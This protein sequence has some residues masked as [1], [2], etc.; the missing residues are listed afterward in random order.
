MVYIP[1]S[2]FG[3]LGFFVMAAFLLSIFSLEDESSSISKLNDAI[4]ED[5]Q[6]LQSIPER[7][8]NESW[9]DAISNMGTGIWYIFS[10]MFMV[11]LLPFFLFADLLV[12]LLILPKEFYIVGVFLGMG[13]FG[14]I[15]NF[16]RGLRSG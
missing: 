4:S 5:T 1:G 9:Y 3:I 16:I 8:G 2:V 15:A 6:S 12:Y 10:I 13:L 14:A 7:T 11:L